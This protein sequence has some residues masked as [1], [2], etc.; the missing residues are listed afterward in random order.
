[1]QDFTLAPRVRITTM[2][3]VIGNLPVEPHS[4][5]VRIWYPADVAASA[6]RV[7]YTHNV[8]L[9]GKPLFPWATQGI[10]AD[11]AP[12]RAGKRF[13]PAHSPVARLWRVERICE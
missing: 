8:A 7:R 3:A 10:A 6:P 5:K 9:P 12:A 1:V 4:L 2:G 13:L 11:A